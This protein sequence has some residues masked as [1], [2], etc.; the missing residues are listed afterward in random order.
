[1]K[2]IKSLFIVAL[3]LVV[4]DTSFAQRGPGR[5]PRDHRGPGRD[6]VRKAPPCNP[7]ADSCLQ[8][9]LGKLSTDDATALQ[10]ALAA[11]SALKDQ[12]NQLHAAAKAAREAKDS[13]A[14]SAAMQ[15]L[16][17]LRGQGKEL[18]RTIRDIM[19]RNS[20]A[21]REAL[22]ACC[23]ERPKGPRDSNDVKGPVHDQ[24]ILHVS[25]IKPNPVL[26]GT[27]SAEFSY[28]LK[29]EAIVTITI[30]DQLGNIIKTVS[31]GASTIGEH[32]VS[33]DLMG[34]TTGGYL[35]RVQ[36]GTDVKTLRLI[37]Q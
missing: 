12:V 15:Q 32:V 4:A 18:S 27:P 5:G 2:N 19:H 20:T 24:H 7:F 10:A 30:N 13:A 1:M 33:L 34:M 3:L 22:V 25:P 6:S 14:F 26:A 37:I 35:V 36:A 29:A 31:S 11:Q 28:S 9:L 21:V 23:G 8:I 17:A 16:R